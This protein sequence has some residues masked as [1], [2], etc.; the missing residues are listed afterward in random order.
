MQKEGQT[1]QNFVTEL[2][3]LSE[4]C[5]FQDLKDSLIKDMII[6]GIVDNQLRERMLREPNINLVK[7]IQ[8]GQAAEETKKHS[9]ELNLDLQRKPVDS[10]KFRESNQ[11]N[12]DNIINKCKF[13]S[14]SHL[15]GKCPAYGKSCLSCN[16]KNHYAK[17]CNNRKAINEIETNSHLTNNFNE[18]VIDA[19]SYK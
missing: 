14:L 18:F 7:S 8:L 12:K 10:I 17:C 16:K 3:Q 4:D 2:R 13:C 9:K 5:E 6:C 11:I 15:R 19:I 1:F